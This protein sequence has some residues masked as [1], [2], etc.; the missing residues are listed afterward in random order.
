M[1]TIANTLKFIE[2]GL[3]YIC[4][5]P[6]FLRSEVFR[7]VA[8]PVKISIGSVRNAVTALA[9]VFLLGKVLGL[10]QKAAKE[11]FGKVL[12]G[13][14]FKGWWL[15]VLAVL[16]G[17][18][19]VVSPE[20]GVS[21]K[22]LR[23]ILVYFC[24]YFAAFE[25]VRSRK[26]VSVVL[27]GFLLSGF[28]VAVMSL[29][30]RYVF[31]VELRDGVIIEDY[32]FWPGKNSLGFFL[33]CTGC[34]GLGVFL[35]LKHWAGRVGTAVM[36]GVVVYALV[37]T[38]SRSGWLAF[39][40]GAVVVSA[41]LCPLKFWP[42]VIAALLLAG[43][44]GVW[45]VKHYPDCAVSKRLLKISPKKDVGN[46]ERVLLWQGAVEMIKDHPVS[47]VGLGRFDTAHK[48]G[49]KSEK[50]RYSWYDTRYHAHNFFLQVFTEMG[51]PAG[52]MF[53]LCVLWM[54]RLVFA[55][56]RQCCGADKKVVAGICGVV[57][58]FVAYSL[59][60]TTF[61]ARFSHASMFHAN[62]VLLLLCVLGRVYPGSAKKAGGR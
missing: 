39:A 21:F 27:W 41:L 48:Q 26:S 47:G 56:F 46:Y 45:T 54:F 55:N 2:S 19:C 50:S 34:A 8:G 38:F 13:A 40:F 36:L 60:D 58:A 37:F 51:I 53:L 20:P 7:F 5:L 22:S 44:A 57:A 32:M 61:N 10:A 33:A 31:D 15:A 23:V 3:F 17:L 30:S 16:L 59:V 1:N 12:S 62:L 35:S 11:G 24:F 29:M 52:T 14:G 43:A 18:N 49:Y 42:V 9:V 28:F 25:C 6:L 4:L